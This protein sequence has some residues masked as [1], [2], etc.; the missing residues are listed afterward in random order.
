MPGC[1]AFHSLIFLKLKYKDIVV[2]FTNAGFGQKMWNNMHWNSLWVGMYR[3]KFFF[4]RIQLKLYGFSP[5]LSSLA[6]E[7]SSCN[8]HIE[9]ECGNGECINYQLTCDGIAHCKDKSDEKM[10][11]CGKNHFTTLCEVC[12]DKINMFYL[13]IGKI[14]W[15]VPVRVKSTCWLLSVIDTSDTT[16]QQR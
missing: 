10:Q 9:F 2:A 12:T 11:Y 4:Q 15:F 8:I 5:S 13:Y 14:S 16:R 6:A 3:M 7:N 1:Q